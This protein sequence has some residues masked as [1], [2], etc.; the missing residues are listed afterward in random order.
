LHCLHCLS[1]RR[2]FDGFNFSY[3]R[4]PRF[5]KL[6]DPAVLPQLTHVRTGRN[7]PS[8]IWS[9]GCAPLVTVYSCNR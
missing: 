3:V 1:Y 8:R 2:G 4:P 7:L 6:E 9:P 5:G